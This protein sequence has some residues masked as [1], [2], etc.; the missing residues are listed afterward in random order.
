MSKRLLSVSIAAVLVLGGCATVPTG[1]AVMVLPGYQKS[2]DQFRADEGDCRGYAQMAIGGP[3]ANQPANDAAA[4]N[5]VGAAAL[6]AAA[7]AILGSV[8]G[9]AGNGAAIGAGT[10]L[11][12]GSAASANTS[13]FSSYQLQRQYDVAY[14]Q[15]M[16]ARGNQVP[17]QVAY[18]GPPPGA[19]VPNYIPPEHHAALPAGELSVAEL[20]AA[21][22]PAFGSD[23]GQLSAA[24]HAAA[25]QFAG[26][27][28]AHASARRAPSA[29]RV[30]GWRESRLSA[31]VPSSPAGCT[32]WWRG[33]PD[34]RR[35]RRQA[36]PPARARSCGAPSRRET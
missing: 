8:T 13:G 18:R 22:L 34:C 19:P 33:T 4:A 36:R 20:P 24:Q 26:G 29:A 3:N 25:A 23:A 10:G 9:H 2:F 1:P 12:F 21:E 35:R 14:L 32:C 30:R 28:L 7:G 6:G 27:Q 31:S 16:Y 15:C 5:A 17:G 11:L